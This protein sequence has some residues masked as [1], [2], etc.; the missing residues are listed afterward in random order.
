MAERAEARTA[1]MLAAAPLFSGLSERALRRLVR[2]AKERTYSAGQAIVREGDDGI[3]FFLIVDGEV[4]VRKGEQRKATLRSGDFFGEMA[5]F[6]RQPRTAD[7]VAAR[8]TRCLVL[9][10]WEFWGFMDDE[11]KVMRSLMQE[12]VRRLRAAGAPLSE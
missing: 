7:V 5:L 1:R 4:E 8:P 10:T 9:S 12:M 6:D 3:G 2:S 11:P